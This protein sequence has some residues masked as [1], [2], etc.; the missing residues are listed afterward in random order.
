VTEAS[1]EGRALFT[2]R[3]VVTANRL[4]FSFVIALIVL[5]NGV[6]FAQTPP[7]DPPP[8]TEPVARIQGLLLNADD[9]YRDNEADIVELSG[10]VQIVSQDRHIQADKARILL[11][12]KQLEL[13][14]NVK[15]T[16]SSSTIGGERI[17]LDYESTTGIIYNGY[18]QSGPVIFEGSI[19]QK[20]GP[21]EYF[22][23]NADYTTCTNCPGSWSF[24]GTS[25]RAELGGYAYIK[26]SVLKF[27]SLP[28]LWLPYLV[29]PLKSDRQ[30]G[31][32]TPEF[33]QSSAGGFTVAQPYFWAISHSTD[34]TLTLKNYELRGLKALVN[35]R[36]VLNPDSEGEL[37]FATLDD[38]AFKNE[39][40]L[41][42]FRPLSQKGN[43]TDR[44][45]LRYQHYQEHS[46]GWVQR[47][48]IN[49]ASDLQYPRDFPGET[50]NHGDSAMESRMSMTKNTRDRH[51]SVDSSYYRN[52][53]QANPLAGNE[54]AVHRMPELR[55]AQIPRPIGN[56]EFYYGIDLNLVNFTRSGPGYDNMSYTTLDGTPVRYVSND[57]NRPLWGST[58]T[59]PDD[60]NCANT[61]DGTFTS[62]TDLIRT[63]QRF[64]IQ[65]SIFR[66]FTIGNAVDLMPKVSY[67]E[68]HYNFPVGQEKNN[69]RRY[70]R[71]ELAGRMNFSRVYGD[72]NDRRSNRF[73]H[74]I[75][76]EVTYTA[77]PFVDHQNHPFFGFTPQTEAPTFENSAVTDADLAGNSGLQFDY[78]DRI[79]DRNLVTYSIVNTV[80]EKRWIN[81]TPVYRQLA[82]LKLSQSFDAWKDGRPGKNQEPYSD[83]SGVADLRFDH[84]QT[85]TLL[86]YYPYQKVTNSSARLRVNDDLG[87]F[88]Q[89]GLVKQFTIV[90]GKDVDSTARVE[91]YTLGS[92]F[93]SRYVNLMGKFTY[94]AAE[95]TTKK[96]KSWAYIAQM[97]PPGDCWMITFIHDQVTG[98]ETN[99]KLNFDFVFD[100]VP[101]PPLPPETLDSFGF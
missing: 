9:F 15:L 83:I 49:N 40:R 70:L 13:N 3:T 25:I 63:G 51:F 39:D 54:E 48:M 10:H 2:L 81:E 7:Q 73:R 91:D 75:R 97:K 11:R 37:D 29:V 31:L 99:F 68:T 61:D 6:G 41:N 42:D 19:I 28:V 44:W 22:V 62:G 23:Q 69:V 57:C 52:L 36:Y 82:F 24:R 92:G 74:E 93:V 26:N 76:P 101:K 60:A 55:Y 21:D 86:N 64:D 96:I 45:F 30:S 5:A 20:I 59:N 95:E 50:K 84:F 53:L 56:S 65:P 27:G 43:G 35:Y 78:R 34:T 8:V 77:L 17:V 90:P 38:R 67:R 46:D 79:F 12:T 80:T 16:M 1:T 4:R 94:N 98:G 85:Y 88:A 47:A 32:L 72:L 71:T 18:V 33:E 89:I 58:T 66:T 14:G 87:R 100:G